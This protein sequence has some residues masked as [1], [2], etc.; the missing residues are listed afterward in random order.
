M[1]QNVHVTRQKERD[2][3]TGEAKNGERGR[4]G[5]GGDRERK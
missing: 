3:K 2:L 5:G 1:G 4:E